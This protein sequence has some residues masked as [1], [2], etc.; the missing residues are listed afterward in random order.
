[1]TMKNEDP[2]DRILNSLEGIRSVD[3]PRA[4]FQKIQ[5]KLGAQKTASISMESAGKGWMWIA[6]SLA[7]V[8]CSN[9]WLISD[10]LDSGFSSEPVEIVSE[11]PALT[12][13]FNLYDYE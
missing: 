2:V 1:M 5:Q 3:A 10:R 4:S 12:S 7:L 8:L 9:I 6:A 11:Y 13:D